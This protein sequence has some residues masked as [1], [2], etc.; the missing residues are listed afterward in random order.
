MPPTR[1]TPRA[2]DDPAALLSL[3]E[4]SV[5]A[6]HHFLDEAD[7]AFYRPL[8]ADILSSGTLEL[9][10]LTNHEDAPLGFIGLAANAI[11]ALFLEPTC[12]GQGYGRL[13]VAHAQERLGGALAVDVNEQNTQRANSTR[14]SDSSSWAGRRSTTPVRPTP[15]CIY[16]ERHQGPSAPVKQCGRAGAKC[17]LIESFAWI[18]Y[19][20][21]ASNRQ[22]GLRRR[23][24]TGNIS[25]WCGDSER[26]EAQESDSRCAEHAVLAIDGETGRSARIRRLGCVRGR[27]VAA[28]RSPLPPRHVVRAESR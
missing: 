20:E 3:W 11:E 27:G 8:V 23:S 16:G 7:I 1:H 19:R 5:R 13:L 22:Y 25:H 21:A 6:T 24:N 4:R 14:P 28:C 9:W 18:G 26:C 17:C 12:R 10:V 2:A 15:S